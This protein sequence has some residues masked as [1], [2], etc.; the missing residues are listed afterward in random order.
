MKEQAQI[1]HPYY[2]QLKSSVETID[3]INAL[4]LTKGF[5]IGNALKYIIRSGRKDSESEQSDLQ[6]AIWY[7]NYYNDKWLKAEELKEELKNEGTDA[8]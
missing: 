8:E 6:K 5:C 7:L 4:G 2:Y 3:I 1:N